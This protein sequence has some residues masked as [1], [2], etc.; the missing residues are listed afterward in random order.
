M[1]GSSRSSIDLLQSLLTTKPKPASKSRYIEYSRSSTTGKRIY[2][3]KTSP[4][5]KY[6]KRKTKDATMSI[7][8]TL[9]DTDDNEGEGKCISFT[10]QF[11][12]IDFTINEAVLACDHH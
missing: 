4:K 2:K 9:N 12:T 6:K 3:T 7:G 11:C 8:E 10:L 1:A 5:R